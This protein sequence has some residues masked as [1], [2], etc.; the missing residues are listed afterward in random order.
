MNIDYDKNVLNDQKIYTAFNDC[1]TEILNS[2]ITTEEVVIAAK[3]LKNNKA[4][5]SDCITN[6]MLQIS[7]NMNIDVYVKLFNLILKSGIYPTLWREYF[8]KPI[9]K[10]GYFND[11]SNYRGF[12]S[13]SVPIYV[14]EAAPASIR[15]A[16]VSLN[17]LFITIGILLSSIVAGAFS[18]DKENGWRY[19]LGIAGVPSFIQFVGFFFLP[20]SPRYLVNKGK[21][22]EARKVLEKLRDS[23]NVDHEMRDIEKSV[24]E[25]REF[26]QSNVFATIAKMLGNQPVR[27]AL[28]L[29]CL[30]QLF[31]QL[32]GINT[33][34]NLRIL[35]F[36]PSEDHLTTGSQW[37]EWLEGIERKFRYFRIKDLEDKKDAM[38]IYGGKEISRLEKSTPDPVDRC[39]GVYEKLKKK[40]NDY[41]AQKKNKHYA[42]YVFLK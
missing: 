17:Q 28:L 24:K 27:K 13:M 12:A 11:P 8:I 30:M 39:M 23:S 18:G 36:T 20:E 42:R 5:C 41:F 29:G 21:I 10:G 33:V 3:S 14:A 7:C 37:E 26:E 4:S 32:C 16:L 15:G 19:M 25:S 9:F 34:I 31:Q 40:L 22:E 38:I 2:Y 6:E 35:P 1:N